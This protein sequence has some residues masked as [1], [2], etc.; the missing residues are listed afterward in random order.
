MTAR[1]TQ[2]E[3]I[4]QTRE[5]HDTIHQESEDSSLP[6]THE[7]IS[8]NIC[9]NTNK[10]EDFYFKSFKQYLSNNIGQ[11]YYTNPTIRRFEDLRLAIVSNI[12]EANASLVDEA[13]D[14]A[15]ELIKSI[16]FQYKPV[17]SVRDLKYTFVNLAHKTTG[18]GKILTEEIIIEVEQLLAAK[19]KKEAIEN[20]QI[21]STIKP[22]RAPK[23]PENTAQRVISPIA[24]S[25]TKGKG[26][27]LTASSGFTSRASTPEPH[28]SL[29]IQDVSP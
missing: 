5:E 27:A 2:W 23:S 20:Q 1:I 26:K 9:H 28:T 11:F 16:R 3:D 14:A 13:F 7:D 10:A 18:F 6:I 19:K 8:C 12:Q 4:E 15:E 29:L 21:T 17:Y 25:P 22:I 24:A